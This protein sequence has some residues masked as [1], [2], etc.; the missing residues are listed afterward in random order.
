MK[1]ILRTVT[2]IAGLALS[3]MRAVASPLPDVERMSDIEVSE[4]A[5]QMSSVL[6][7]I[8]NHQLCGTND[9]HCVRAEFARHGISYDDR[10]SVQ[11]RVILMIGSVY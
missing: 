1:H 7:S 2:L 10:E 3:S 8:Q 11:K 9:T 4:Y 5:V 6:E